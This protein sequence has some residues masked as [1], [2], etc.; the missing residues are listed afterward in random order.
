TLN[1]PIKGNGSGFTAGAINLATSEVTGT[2]PIARG[3]TNGTAT[4]TNGGIAYGNGT[5][6]AFTAVG[7]SG[8]VLRSNGAAAPTW[9]NA[10]ALL[11][12]GTGITISTNTINSVWTSNG[13]NIYNNN[14][15][16]VGIGA[17]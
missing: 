13:T 10:G 6:Y 12:G 2:L 17:T 8:Q 3:G 4:P 15:S 9:S 14:S 5:A 16:N 1:G 7:T 11:T